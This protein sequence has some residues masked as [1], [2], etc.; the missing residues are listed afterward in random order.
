MCVRPATT[1]SHGQKCQLPCACVVQNHHKHPTSTK[2]TKF[3]NKPQIGY[4]RAPLPCG[5]TNL[6]HSLQRTVF[7]TPNDSGHAS[8]H[9]SYPFLLRGPV[10]VRRQHV[11]ASHLDLARC[12]TAALPQH[13][14]AR[15]L[16]GNLLVPEVWA[17]PITAPEPIPNTVMDYPSHE[18]CHDDCTLRSSPTPT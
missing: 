8:Q 11:E 7:A 9:V 5:I 15:R 10:A 12:V 18:S 14:A 4:P 3:L 13:P 17:S 6:A 2:D 16:C 1:V